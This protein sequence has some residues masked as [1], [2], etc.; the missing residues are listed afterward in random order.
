MRAGDAVGVVDVDGD[1]GVGAAEVYRHADSRL[2]VGDAL[3]AVYYVFAAALEFFLEL[4]QESVAVFAIQFV[5]SAAGDDC[6]ACGDQ[7]DGEQQ[8]E[9]EA[10]E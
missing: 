4:G 2:G 1:V 6:D 8:R 10:D 7:R 9:H 5:E 3:H